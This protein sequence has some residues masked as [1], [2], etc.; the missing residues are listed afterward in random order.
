MKQ[1]VLQNQGKATATIGGGPLPDVPYEESVTAI[2]GDN[3]NLVDGTEGKWSVTLLIQH[4]CRIR[5]HLISAILALSFYIPM[6]SFHHFTSFQ[7]QKR[8]VML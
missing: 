5:A 6:H 1:A 7:V 4:F 8:H 3:T 2:I